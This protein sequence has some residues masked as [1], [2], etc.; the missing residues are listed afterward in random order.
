M[1]DHS[2]LRS[3]ITIGMMPAIIIPCSLVAMV[4][5]N[6][7]YCHRQASTSNDEPTLKQVK[8]QA[9]LPPPEAKEKVVP[10]MP[11]HKLITCTVPPNWDKIL[12]SGKNFCTLTNSLDA[13]GTTLQCP[14][15]IC[16]K[17]L[18]PGCYTGK[19]CFQDASHAFILA[20]EKPQNV[21]FEKR[22]LSACKEH[23]LL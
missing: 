12:Q 9:K 19:D 21:I 3:N 23:T 1:L 14:S 17:L 13:L 7:V 20:L 2:T 6:H 5:Q 4:L 16:G 15:L 11:L 8:F 18:L 10:K 22:F